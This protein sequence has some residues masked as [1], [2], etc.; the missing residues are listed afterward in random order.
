MVACLSVSVVAVEAFGGLLVLA[1]VVAF[2]ATCIV[3]A[4]VR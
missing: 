2:E 1:T 3:F 4:A